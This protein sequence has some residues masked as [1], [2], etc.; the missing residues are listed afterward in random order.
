MV[1][2]L[3]WTDNI[4]LRRTGTTHVLHEIAAL[5]RQP[6]THP[7]NETASAKNLHPN[8]PE[9]VQLRK[10]LVWFM[11]NKGQSPF[12]SKNIIVQHCTNIR[13]CIALA[14][15]VLIKLNMLH[16]F[17]LASGIH[18]VC[19][20]SYVI[21]SSEYCTIVPIYTESNKSLRC[22]S[23]NSACENYQVFASVAVID[24][25]I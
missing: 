6:T 7:A 22:Y 24:G 2:N 3:W 9:Y 8:K 23:V 15:I 12:T 13:K 4:S 16:D 18:T 20:T 14:P 21:T 11:A 19:S 10:R 17:A 25:S 5:T 1:K